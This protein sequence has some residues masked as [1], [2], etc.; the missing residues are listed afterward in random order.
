MTGT[1]GFNPS[2]KYDFV[3]WDDEIPYIWKNRKGSKPPTR[4]D[5][6][7]MNSLPTA[8]GL[9]PSMI[10]WHQVVPSPRNPFFW[11]KCVYIYIIITITII[12]ITIIII[13]IFIYI[14]YYYHLYNILLYYIYT[15]TYPWG[16]RIPMNWDGWC[17]LELADALQSSSHPKALWGS[18][19]L[20]EHRFS[21][22]VADEAVPVHANGWNQPKWWLAGRFRYLVTLE[23]EKIHGKY[24]AEDVAKHLHS[25]STWKHCIFGPHVTL[26][27][28]RRLL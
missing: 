6:N 5:S 8:A 19:F 23:Q 3:T 1:G 21:S 24:M 12:I 14:Y 7:G 28:R 10:S 9:C 27:G 2:E 20:I 22:D 25:K 4:W 18:I 26:R 16:T 15:H 17:A 11:S 13:S